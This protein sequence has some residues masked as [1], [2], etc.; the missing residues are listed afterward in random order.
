[1]LG[2]SRRPRP[3]RVAAASADSF[4]CERSRR[5]WRG[6]DL[7]QPGFAGCRPSPTPSP[8]GRDWQRST[9]QHSF[10]RRPDRRRGQ[11]QQGNDDSRVQSQEPLQ[12]VAVHLRSHH[13]SRRPD[14]HAGA[15][16]VAIGSPAAA[17]E[18]VQSQLTGNVGLVWRDAECAAGA[19]RHSSNSKKPRDR[20][21][22]D[23]TGEDARPPLV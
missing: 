22:I 10:W 13:G 14:H 18:F 15:A 19:A 1:M 11:H 4:W 5:L 9:L 6:R 23:L 20:S 12:P 21:E 3:R 7:S 2:R 8:G 17:A 16:C